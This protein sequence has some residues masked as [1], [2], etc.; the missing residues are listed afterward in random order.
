MMYS[1]F[2]QREFPF[3][4]IEKVKKVLKIYLPFDGLMMQ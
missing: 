1:I 2:S 4:L 3:S